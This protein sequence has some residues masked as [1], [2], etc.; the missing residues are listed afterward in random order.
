MIKGIRIG[1]TK[2]NLKFYDTLVV[3]IIKNTSEEEDLRDRM[4]E[5]MTMYL[6]SVQS[7]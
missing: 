5:A 4:H 3:P 6:K 1:N 2:N 7:S